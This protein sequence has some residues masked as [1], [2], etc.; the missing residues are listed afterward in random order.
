M[1]RGIRNTKT[2]SFRWKPSVYKLR[3]A[4][5]PDDVPVWDAPRGGDSESGVRGH[6]STYEMLEHSFPRLV[7]TSLEKEP[8]SYPRDLAG[9]DVIN[10]V[11]Q[12]ASEEWLAGRQPKRLKN[13]VRH[14]SEKYGA[15][16]RFEDNTVDAWMV[17]AVR[18]RT[19]LAALQKLQ[20][21]GADTAVF[22]LRRSA[23]DSENHMT[24]L[25]AWL[26]DQ[27]KPTLKFADYR[28]AMNG[29][30]NMRSKL[31]STKIETL[32]ALTDGADR[33]NLSGEH[34]VEQFKKLVFDKN[35]AAFNSALTRS[36]TTS[37][38]AYFPLEPEGI[39][40]SCALGVWLEYKL[41]ELWRSDLE[42]LN[43]PVCGT[44]F[45]PT[46]SNMKYCRRG[47]CADKKYRDSDQQ[48]EQ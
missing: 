33:L 19:Q 31:A 29:A 40:L 14:L 42:V 24:R 1:N 22:W 41:S 9:E 20:Q 16:Y 26:A 12:L 7:R 3:W 11:G 10:D 2:I 34:G 18:V 46:R 36:L 35:R 39:A 5:V 21:Q 37:S 27:E 4:E 38:N 25:K 43:C 30:L 15:P 13:K 8:A 32:A 47:T 23:I 45:V 48:G 6:P 28:E 17:L 44:L